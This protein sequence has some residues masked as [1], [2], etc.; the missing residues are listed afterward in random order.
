MC[1]ACG[2]GCG[3]DVVVGCSGKCDVNVVVDVMGCGSGFD[4]AVWWW[5]YWWM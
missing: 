4:V 2:G 1:C 5:M 3:V